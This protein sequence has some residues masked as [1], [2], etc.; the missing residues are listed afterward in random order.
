MNILPE[1][2]IIVQFAKILK[3]DV[4]AGP[5]GLFGRKHEEKSNKTGG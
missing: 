2:G 4:I 3:I 5:L 1:N